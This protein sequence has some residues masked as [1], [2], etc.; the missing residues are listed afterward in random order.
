MLLANAVCSAAS[1]VQEY[2]LGVGDVLNIQVV[3][4]DSASNNMANTAN[5]NIASATTVNYNTGSS[6]YMIRPDGKFEFPFI[7]EVS[8]A[9]KTPSQ[10][11]REITGRLAE[12]LKAPSVA[13]NVTKFHTTRVY[14]LGEVVRPG[15]Y[16]LER[17]HNLV[18]SIGIAGGYTK[19]AAKKTIFVIRD[20]NKDEP[21]VCN[22][23]NMLE[24]GDSSQNIELH[25]GDVVYLSNN[26]KIDWNLDIFPW[27]QA[28]ANSATA[29]ATVYA[30]QGK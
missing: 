4:L 3:G 15:L 5:T 14:V 28:I 18:D 24:K 2:L 16:E 7:G 13:I 25:D 23:L 21:I 17:E 26:G 9:G 29:V 30:I 8:A 11:N 1:V 12:Y 19:Y 27:F 20:S 22:L 10:L 6:G